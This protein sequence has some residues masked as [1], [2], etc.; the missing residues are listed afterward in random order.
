VGS[1]FECEVETKALDGP[2]TTY[3]SLAYFFL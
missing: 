1:F 3:N 2:I